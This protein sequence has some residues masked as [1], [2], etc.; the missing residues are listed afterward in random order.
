MV[1]RG[2]AGQVQNL[3]ASPFDQLPHLSSLVGRQL[4]HDE[5]L[6][7]FQFG[8]EDLLQ[9][10]F[11]TSLVVEPSTAIEGPIPSTV[12]LAKSVVFLPRLRGTDSFRRSPLGE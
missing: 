9:I 10:G 12:M 8:K 4:I 6:P 2:V 3:A 1:V 11:E 5:H 7:F